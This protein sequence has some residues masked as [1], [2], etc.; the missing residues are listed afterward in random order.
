METVLE[1][2]KELGR[3]TVA[4]SREFVQRLTDKELDAKKINE[5]L[6]ALR[7]NLITASVDAVSF[8]K[9]NQILS[10]AMSPGDAAESW[11]ETRALFAEIEK[12]PMT[13][14][15]T[16]QPDLDELLEQYV[17]LLR[18]LSAKADAE[19]RAYAET[20]HLLRSPANARRL[21][22]AAKDTSE[23]KVTRWGSVAE[24]IKS[25]RG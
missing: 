5:T 11:K 8:L 18:K 16:G 23:G 24:L 9:V 2:L 10:R 19:Y 22:Q 7:Q 17:K 25:K 21:E 12:H 3:E 15:K 4:S 1:E 20:A 13:R 6:S 14:L